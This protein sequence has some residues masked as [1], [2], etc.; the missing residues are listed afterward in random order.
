[1]LLYKLC[2]ACNVTTV[3]AYRALRCLI[4]TVAEALRFIK[5][6]LDPGDKQL[7]IPAPP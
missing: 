7:W 4:R 1:M 2:L 5:S 6:S 3:K